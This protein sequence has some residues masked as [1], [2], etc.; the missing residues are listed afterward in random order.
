LHRFR[1]TALATAALAA[2]AIALSACGRDDADLINGKTEFVGKCGSCHVLARAGTKGIQ[3]PSLD[4]AFTTPRKDGM[5]AKTVEGVVL[6]QIAHP[7]RNSIMPKGLDKG[8]DAHDV[9]AYVGYAAGIGG[10]DT[11][12]LA[13]A[14]KPKTSN[15]PIAAKGGKLTIDAIDG[16]AFLSTAATAPAGALEIDMPNKSSDQ[17]NIELKDVPNAAGKVVGKGQTSSIK[18]DLKPGKYTYFC[19]VPGH[20]AA[21]MKGTLTVK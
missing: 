14:G 2:S 3:G 20:E 15:K 6:R 17:H 12:P 11:G 21:G 4:A 13:D 7:R 10:K 5:T 19:A 18:V 9:A 8:D 16:T 1:H